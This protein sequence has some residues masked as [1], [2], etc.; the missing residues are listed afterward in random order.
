MPSG[1]R[2]TGRPSRD[3]VLAR[4]GRRPKRWNGVRE[5]RNDGEKR[6]TGESDPGE[7]EDLRSSTTPPET[8]RSVS[9]HSRVGGYHRPGG[10]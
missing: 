1:I 6:G 5:F 3:E 4:E 7:D 8:D 2:G 9:G 10:T